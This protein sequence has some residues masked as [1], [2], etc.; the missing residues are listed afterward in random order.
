MN[1]YINKTD[2]SNGPSIFGERLKKELQ[3]QGL[4]YCPDSQNLIHIIN[5][6]IKKGFNNI[7]RLDGLYLDSGN[8]LGNTDQLNSEILFSYRAAEKVVFQSEFSKLCYE[9][10]MGVHKDSC[11]IRNGV[12]ESFYS[13]STQTKIKKPKRFKKIAIASAEWRRHKRIEEVIECFKSPKLKDFGLI[14][15]GGYKNI[16]LPNVISLPK[17]PIELLPSYYKIS[18]CMIHLS[19]LDW[20]PNTVVE[21]LA[22]G[23]P[24]LCSS[25]GGTKELVQDSGIVLDI[26]EKYQIGTQVD[27]YNP[28]KVDIELIVKNILDLFEIPKVSRPD[29]HIKNSAKLYKKLFV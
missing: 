17:I 20:C 11:I 22:S 16:D 15:L 28:P 1:F 21:G 9:N 6:S 18:D 27:L 19:W 26:E 4:E 10:L 23:L 24:V 3:S 7:L 25:N 5:G 2:A 14:I 29:L 12:P 8:T 13:N